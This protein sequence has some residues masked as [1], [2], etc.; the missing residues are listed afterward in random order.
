MNRKVLF[1]LFAISLAALTACNVVVASNQ[2]VRGSGKVA[3]E[4]RAVSGLTDISHSTIGDLT[5]TLGDQETLT[6]E[7]ED[8]LLP[9]LETQVTNGG[10]TIRSKSRVDLLPSQPVRYT[11]TVKN[12]QSIANSSSGNILVPKITGQNISIN[13]SSSGNITVEGVK[14][15]ML[16]VQSS[17]SGDIAIHA[18][19]AGR[20]EISLFSSGK[21]QAADV[22]SQSTQIEISSSG[23][24][25]IWVSDQLDANISSSGNVNT[26]GSPRITQHLSSSGKVIQM[27][28][29]GPYQTPQSTSD[30]WTT[31]SLSEVGMDEKPID[32][33]LN[34]LSQPN[35]HEI[36]GLLV[37]KDGKLVFESYYPGN[38]MLFTDQ[39]A[40]TMKDFDRD[41]QH[42]LASSTKS[43]T[44]ILFGIAVD[45]GEI[46][47]VDESMFTSFPEYEELNDLVKGKITL[48]DMLT[49]TSGLPWDESTYS[50][51]DPRNDID[52]LFLSPDP[53]RY[54]LERQVVSEPGT[55]WLYNSGTVNLLGAVLN[56]KTGTPLAKY[57]AE[58]LFSRLGI[59]SY[60][61]QSFQHAPDL[62]I[63]SSLL[64]LRPRDMAKLGQ[65]F[66]QQ[67][68]W[69]GKQVVSAQWV[70]E[71]TDA[72]VKVPIDYGPG[73]QNTGY[74]YLWWR[75]VFTQGNT[76]V[77]YSAGYGGQFI[78]VMP[79]I[80]TVVVMTGSNFDH[81]YNDMFD[82]VNS[83]ILGSIIR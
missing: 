76:E 2:V 36:N 10:L 4:T 9:Y 72:S 61:W 34:L 28:P 8:N 74:G 17:S 14:A 55:A 37:V 41:T 62:A 60:Q 56:R 1:T 80:H 64:Y 52:Q 19:Q 78:F 27:G 75:G 81:S 54:M 79:S 82:I 32:D 66:L 51:S 38:D 3:S 46:S 71:S 40:F 15:D 33:L 70:K 13:L 35:E 63:T 20:Q 45:R 65:L 31:A 57:A 21:Y 29:K 25:N 49:M 5:I 47:S 30:G 68:M 58:N 77:Y 69:N 22:K 18:G 39:P 73:F 83:Y 26:Y 59:T 11:L 42:C 44:S 23:E 53:I 67:G 7:A 16:K 12:L 24:A 6:V 43:V 48:R 50:Y